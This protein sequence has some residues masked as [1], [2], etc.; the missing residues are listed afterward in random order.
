MRKGLT[1]VL[2]IVLLFA[3]SVPAMAEGE[4]QCKIGETSFAS[5]QE[6]VNA[7]TTEATIVLTADFA[8][9]ESVKITGGKE[10]TLDLA[11]HT[12]TGTDTTTTNFGL[13]DNIK[14]TLTVID[15]EGG[16]TIT[17]VATHD[18]DWGSYS[19]VLAN[20]QG[21][22][23]IKGGTIE[24]LGGTDMAYA[25]DSLTNGN[26]GNA[27]LTIEDGTI[28]STYRGIRQFANSTSKTNSLVITGGTISGTNKAVWLHAS[29]AN[30]N[31]GTLEIKD[32]ATIEGDIYVYQFGD[33]NAMNARNGSKLSLQVEQQ[34]LEGEVICGLAENYA[35]VNINGVYGI[36]GT[37]KVT[38]SGTGVA[39]EKV[40]G[41]AMIILA[42]YAEEKLLRIK[43]IPITGDGTY[44]FAAAG[45]V[46]DGAD[47]I[48][49]FLWD[50]MK[51]MCKPAVKSLG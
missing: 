45:F 6:A 28:R 35:L 44:T 8:Q 27:I 30:A 4:L 15:S 46:L 42:S 7:V 10:I 14:S 9:I 31:I 2:T 17:L 12:I 24:H 25:V 38:L 5:L 48:E 16:G 49:A 32:D 37:P 47:S 1:W 41:E 29:N 43:A 19:A 21:T 39:A 13:I 34:C 22:L 11:G 36:L 50:T 33:E 26:I 20:T 23:T 40:E 3:L 18:R 51:P